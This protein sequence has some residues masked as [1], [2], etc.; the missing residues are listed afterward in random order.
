[1]LNARP[2]TRTSLQCL[3]LSACVA[4]GLSLEVR[5]QDLLEFADNSSLSGVVSG[6]PLDRLPNLLGDFFQS[7]GQQNATFRPEAA[8]PASASGAGVGLGAGAAPVV[9]DPANNRFVYLDAS[10]Q[11]LVPG[12]V[13]LGTEFV[14]FRAVGGGLLTE[15]TNADGV[16]G[17]FGLERVSIDSTSGAQTVTSSV[18][19]LSGTAPATVSDGFTSFTATPATATLSAAAGTTTTP[20]LGNVGLLKMA[21]GGSPIP[22]DRVFFNYNYFE[23]VPLAN[24]ASVNQFV[25]GF[26]KTFLN[27]LMSVEARFP[28]A[29]TLDNDVNVNGSTGTST[30]QIGDISVALKSIFSQGDNWLLSG[31]LQ[32]VLPTAEDLSYSITDGAST[33][34]FIRIENEAVHVM[35]FLGASYIADGGLFLQGFFQIDVDSNGMPVFAN[36]S[37]FGSGTMTQVGS[38]NAA[39]MMYLDLSAGYWLVQE[40]ADS[41]ETLTAIMPLFELHLSRSLTDS[42]S[43]NFSPLGSIGRADDFQLLNTTFGMVFEFQHNTTISAGYATSIPGGNDKDFGGEFRLHVSHRFGTN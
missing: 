28:F 22:R 16:T 41:T 6:S 31:G 9:L 33:R 26:E 4:V 30:G 42:D 1:M 14:F 40:P 12:N 35:P 25:P 20:S 13:A 38:L 18:D 36:S 8:A 23:S 15:T 5:G 34:E 11:L 37:P 29:A 39:T 7:T 21:S 43:V 27:G 24:T 19:I 17:F 32:L 2:T 10:S 3:I